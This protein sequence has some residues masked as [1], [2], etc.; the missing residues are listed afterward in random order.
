MAAD[1]RASVWK[2]ERS[3]CSVIAAQR[4]KSEYVSHYFFLIMAPAGPR[5]ATLS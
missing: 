1:T 4:K 5:A 2:V 3:S